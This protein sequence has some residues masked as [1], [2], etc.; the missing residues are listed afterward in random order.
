MVVCVYQRSNSVIMMSIEQSWEMAKYFV[1]NYVLVLLQKL[2]SGF[3]AMKSI[4]CNE[5][6]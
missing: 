2:P 6:Q 4:L 5:R 3:F 1:Q